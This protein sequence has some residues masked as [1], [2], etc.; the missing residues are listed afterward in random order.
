[1]LALCPWLK[2]KEAAEVA[3][4]EPKLELAFWDK[5]VTLRGAF[6]YKDNILLSSVQPEGSAFWQSGIDL[7]LLRAS[8]ESGPNFTFFLSAEDRRYFSSREIEKEQLLLTQA[9]LEKALSAD[10]TASAA[11][12]YMYVD[13]V[14]DASA[15]EQ[16]LETLPVKGHNI[17]FSPALARTLPWNSTL[18][19]KINIERQYFND[20][21]DDYW[22]T[23]PQLTFTKDYGHKSEAS[24]SYSFDRRAYDERLD[25]DLNFDPVPD[26]SLE[27]LQHEFEFSLN[28]S[29]DANRRWR[30]RLRT[31]MEINDDGSTGFYDYYRYRIS[32]RFGYYG[33]NWQAT[34]EGKVLHY[35][36]SVQPVFEGEGI[37][38]TW[39]YV[40]SGHVEKTVWKKLTL[41]ADIEHEIAV[42]NYPLEEYT[43]TT[44]MGGVDWE[45]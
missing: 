33:E 5:S 36:Y 35:D 18:E 29:W 38:S 17:Q 11:L 9:K 26:S 1:M 42:S 3:E 10:W 30:S 25:R 31:L 8:L 34:I 14:Y 40:V 32:K 37:R 6:G 16:I 4:E 45:F 22:E 44:I 39:E 41:F 43:V 28:H 19:F 24:L 13:Q 15:T 20:P 23:G 12:Q 7:T 2:A 21:L 27:Y